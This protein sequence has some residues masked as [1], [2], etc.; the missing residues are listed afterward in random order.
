MGGLECSSMDKGEIAIQ[1]FV[2]LFSVG[3]RTFIGENKRPK[4][5]FLFS[6]W[7]VGEVKGTVL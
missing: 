6:A 7:H 4:H 1:V 2:S 5:Q 3:L